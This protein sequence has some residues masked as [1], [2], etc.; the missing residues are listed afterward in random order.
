[1]S[2]Q[3]KTIQHSWGLFHATDK[4]QEAQASIL[5]CHER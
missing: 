1:L 4:L 2:I 5:M 3:I